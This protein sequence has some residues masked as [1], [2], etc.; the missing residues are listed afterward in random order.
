MTIIINTRILSNPITGVQRYLLELLQ[1]MPS[2]GT[3]QTGFR[4]K[5]N[6]EKCRAPRL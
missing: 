2:G 6:C 5:N 3:W 1:R 4:R